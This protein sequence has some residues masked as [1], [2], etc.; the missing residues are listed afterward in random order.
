MCV[1]RANIT[2]FRRRPS[3]NPRTNIS[4]N[5]VYSRKALS[6]E[7]VT[8]VSTNALCLLTYMEGIESAISNVA[9]AQTNH[10]N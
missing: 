6:R 5:P 2:S 7:A 4:I 1:L 10:A 3:S 9:I 8:H